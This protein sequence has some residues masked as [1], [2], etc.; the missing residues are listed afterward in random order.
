MG[1]FLLSGIAMAMPAQAQAP[2]TPTEPSSNYTVALTGYNAVPEQTDDTPFDTASGAYS[3]PEVVAA[4]TVDLADRLPFG[5]IIK[6]EGPSAPD[7]DDCGYHAAAPFIGYRVIADSMNARLKGR[8]DILFSTSTAVISAAA[9]MKQ[10]A[11]NTLGICRGSTVR[12][13]GFVDIDRIPKTQ[14][15]LAMLVAR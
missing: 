1:L 12:V 9:G 5:T 6:I 10:N 7:D 11:A 8:V 2:T 3:N 4:R 14:K 15:E 13:V